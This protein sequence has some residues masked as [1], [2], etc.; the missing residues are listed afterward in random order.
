MVEGS[1]ALL[2]GLGRG[3]DAVPAGDRVPHDRLPAGCLDDAPDPASDRW[4]FFVTPVGR[5]EAD[6]FPIN[7]RSVSA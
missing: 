2:D 6:E 5:R 7:A 1:Q 4:A 3:L